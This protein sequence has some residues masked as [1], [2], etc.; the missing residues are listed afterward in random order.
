MAFKKESV[1]LY[2]GFQLRAVVKDD[3]NGSITI[4][5]LNP[6]SRGFGG[7]KSSM[8]VPEK[9]V[10]LYWV[11][12]QEEVVISSVITKTEPANAR[13]TKIYIEKVGDDFFT[14]IDVQTRKG[15][16]YSLTEKEAKA[17]LDIIW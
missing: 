5:K 9:E 8:T 12:P 13:V 16:T 15:L 4:D 1:V 3:G 6:R 17:N 14:Y 2:K 7:K 10:T 11:Q